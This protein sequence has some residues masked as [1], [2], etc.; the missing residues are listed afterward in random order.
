M[1]HWRVLITL[2]VLVSLAVLL[3]LPGRSKMASAQSSSY[4]GFDLN[5]YPGDDG[6]ATLRKTFSFSSYWLNAPPGQKHTNWLGKRALL[7]SHGFGF[8]VLFNGRLSRNL[9][10]AEDARNKGALD[11]EN[12]GRLARQEGFPSG[13]VLFLD[14]EE[15]GRLTDSYHNYVNAWIDAV[16]QQNFRSGAYCS[17]MPVNDGEGQTITTVQDLHNHLTGRKLVL[18]VFNDACPPSPGCVF[19]KSPPAPAQSGIAEAALWQISQSPRRRQFT[20]QCAKTYHADGNC[21]APGDTAHKWFLDVDVAN[22][23]NPSSPQ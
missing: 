5:E 12:A 23:P 11:G 9:K 10:S 20:A 22:S 18:W 13:T 2:F 14:I 7:Q 8:V 16:T 4:L 19:P 21:Y 3:A 6:L 15:G 17:G 1:R